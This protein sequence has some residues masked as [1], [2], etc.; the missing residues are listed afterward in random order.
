MDRSRK[1]SE[2]VLGCYLCRRKHPVGSSKAHCTLLFWELQYLGIN[3]S[4][5]Q[6]L[7][8]FILMMSDIF[9]EVSFQQFPLKR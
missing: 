9:D 7:G 2:S 4:V 8:L 6:G 5:F 3:V 1:W